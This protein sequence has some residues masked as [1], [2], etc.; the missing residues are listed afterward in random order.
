M[1]TTPNTCVKVLEG[2]PFDKSFDHTVY[3]KNREEQYNGMSAFVKHTFTGLTFQRLE[4]GYI[5]VEIRISALY[6]ANYV[7]FT[8]SW[9]QT[10]PYRPRWFYAFV[11]NVAYINENTTRINYTVDPI[12]TW[13]IDC[14]LEKCFVER[15]HS[16]TDAVGENTV[17]ENLGTGDMEAGSLAICPHFNEWVIVVAKAATLSGDLSESKLYAGK[18]FSQVEF[19]TYPLTQAGVNAVKALLAGL[20]VIANPDAVMDIYLLPK[21]FVQTSGGKKDDYISY[22]VTF[23]KSQSTIGGYK[24]KNKKLLTYPYNYLVG[25]NL[26]GAEIEYHYEYFKGNGC[27]FN[28]VP[29]IGV[30]PTAVLMPMGY[31]QGPNL[32]YYTPVDMLSVTNFPKCPYA[33]T[34]G[35]AKFVQS[36]MMLNMGAMAAASANPALLS[37][38]AATPAPA[39][40]ELTTNT[41]SSGAARA[42]YVAANRNALPSDTQISKLLHTGTDAL[43]G[44]QRA[45]GYLQNRKVTVGALNSN[46]AMYLQGLFGFAFMNMHVKVEYARIIDDYFNRFGYATLRNKQPYINTRPH[47]NYVKTSGCTITGKAPGDAINQICKIFDNGITF[48]KNPSEVG[49][50]ELDN[51]PQ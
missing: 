48:W 2:A 24:P 1:A 7:M 17:P 19:E 10:E 23:E 21:D 50:Y 42:A 38:F 43:A 18:Y 44:A 41:V 13:L 32:N 5:D 11:D 51:S 27:T 29:D 34:D 9:N 3:F 15:E 39:T 31:R 8:N 6:A 45:M 33:T 28:L 49:H 40:T 22:Q 16:L 25:S 30:N 14:Q 46:V 4:R 12:Q 36:M 47:W 20:Q 37:T 35:A 26:Q